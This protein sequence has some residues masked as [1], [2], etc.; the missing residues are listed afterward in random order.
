MSRLKAGFIVATALLATTMLSAAAG[1]DPMAQLAQATD[2]KIELND[3]NAIKTS[4]NAEDYQNYL[5][6]YPNGSF[7]D[8]AK[9][10]IKQYA[11]PPAAAPA[12]PAPDPEMAELKDWNAVRL[13]KPLT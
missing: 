3:W 1:A 9:L 7:A 12:E 13:S 4:K 10:R 8:L 2:P 11:P 5:N 6:K